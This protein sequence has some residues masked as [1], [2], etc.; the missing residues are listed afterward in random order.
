[1]SN[2][3]QRPGDNQALTR[4]CDASRRCCKGDIFRE[5][6]LGAGAKSI[7]SESTKFIE[8]FFTFDRPGPDNPVCL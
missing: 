5:N 7:V 2:G 8:N 1:M 4:W 3:L 6:Q